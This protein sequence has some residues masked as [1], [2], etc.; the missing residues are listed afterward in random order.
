[1]LETLD[2]HSYALIED[3]HIEFDKGF[4]A[5]T[6]ETGAGK[7]IMLS[8]VSLLLGGKGDVSMIRTGFENAT[9]CGT[10]TLEPNGG[11]EDVLKEMHIPFEDNVVIIRR[12]LKKTGR[13]LSY[14]DNVPVNRTA[15]LSITS[16]LVD[17]SA[18]HAHQSLLREDKQLQLVDSYSNDKEELDAY[19]KAYNL[20]SSLMQSKEEKVKL[21]AE[22]KR[23]EDYLQ[24][25]FQE[26]DKIDP[27][28]G[29][30]DT[31]SDAIKK[32]SQ[33]E[34]IHD[35]ISQAIQL[36]RSNYDEGSILSN[37]GTG[38][39]CLEQASRHDEELASYVA[40]LKSVE[41][42][43]EDIYESI[44][45]YLSLM[46]YSQTELDNMQSRLSSLQRLT[47]KY[48]PTLT[49]VLKFRDE[50]K[51]KVDALSCGEDDLIQLNKKIEEAH[52]ELLRTAS[53]L[54]S[55]RKKGSLSLA[56][57]IAQSL[58]GLG[59]PHA[60]FSIE[61]H[62][63]T[64]Y[65]NG[66]EKAN[67]MLC[68][69]PGLEVRPLM[70]IASG[71]ELSRVMLAIKATLREKDPV[72]TLWFDEVDAGIGG[73]VASNVATELRHLSESSQILAITHLAS[74]ASKADRQLVVRKE[75]KGQMSY[76]LIDRVEAD[77]RV[78]EI[79]RMLSGD[80]SSHLSLEH[81][82][83]LLSS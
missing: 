24:F 39:A 80:S 48:G 73:V 77:D 51:S 52:K 9:I 70:E 42:E 6:G 75:V 54:S 81:A 28:E 66:S 43:C 79:S 72:A 37:L 35:N 82:K 10:F 45:D 15:L 40:R 71:G 13:T 53:I 78:K 83:E 7:S 1:M 30:D 20:H 41:I 27:K 60:L 21:I 18:Q 65:Y 58:H 5:I 11:V 22:S 44:K 64:P 8:A 57:E 4:T 32:A 59:M 46:T 34:T 23:E 17:I 63:V 49:Q 31:L 62:S 36:F 47:R 3:V 19:Q 2:I 12:I 69:N 67:F 56:K 26:I 14:V 55:K 76:S 16:R 74:I 61:L 68:A 29:E 50:V 25:A 38:V 33:Y